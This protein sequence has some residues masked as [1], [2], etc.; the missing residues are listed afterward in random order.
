MLLMWSAAVLVKSVTIT[1][2]LDFDRTLLVKPISFKGIAF[3]SL[4]IFVGRNSSLVRK[5]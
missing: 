4:P 1:G 5:G 3:L 2:A